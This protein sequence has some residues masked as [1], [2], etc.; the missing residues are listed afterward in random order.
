LKSATWKLFIVFLPSNRF[1]SCVFG[2]GRR[3]P[4]I[5]VHLLDV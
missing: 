4:A 5:P 2:F 1:W 3:L